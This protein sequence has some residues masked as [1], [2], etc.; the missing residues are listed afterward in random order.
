MHF[1][2]I[3]GGNLSVRKKAGACWI[4]NR[5]FLPHSFNEKIKMTNGTFM[6][7]PLLACKAY[8]VF[9]LSYWQASRHHSR[10]SPCLWGSLYGHVWLK[11]LSSL[12]SP[13]FLHWEMRPSSLE[14]LI[15][16]KIQIYIILY[17]YS[18]LSLDFSMWLWLS[19]KSL[20]EQAGLKY[21]E[22]HPP[23]FPECRD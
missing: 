2:S 8:S 20:I 15:S 21:T 3:R 12:A 22:I 4:G 6:T 7:G 14:D 19:W 10:A 5:L 9:L 18:F 11:P 16:C 13:F 17:N 1:Y 23:G